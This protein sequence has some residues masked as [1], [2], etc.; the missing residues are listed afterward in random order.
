MLVQ[1]VNGAFNRMWE[2]NNKGV[3]LTANAILALWI[4][5]RSRAATRVLAFGLHPRLSLGLTRLTLL[6]TVIA[7]H[8]LHR[9]RQTPCTQA[10]HHLPAAEAL[11][12]CEDGQRR[13]R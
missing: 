10:V 8:V 9:V 5:A 6:D 13:R 3:S 2:N 4:S 1:V 11:Q 7:S 12:R